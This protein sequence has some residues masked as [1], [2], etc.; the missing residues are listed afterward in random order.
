MTN[1]CEPSISIEPMVAALVPVFL[2]T[3]VLQDSWPISVPGYLNEPGSLMRPLS[4]PPPLEV[5]MPIS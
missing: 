1:A 4:S 2:I 3:K 5:P